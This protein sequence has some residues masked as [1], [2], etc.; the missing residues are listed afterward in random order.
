MSSKVNQWTLLV[1]SLP[2]VFAIAAG[3]FTGLPIDSRQRGELL[4]TAAQSVFAVAVVSSLSVSVKEALALFSLFWAQFLLGAFVPES[5]HGTEL[6]V[7]SAVYILLGLWLLVRK[8]R[9]FRH[10]LRGTASAPPTAEL[11]PEA[12][13]E[14]PSQV[15]R[16]SK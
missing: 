3:S 13:A 4:L 1:G 8:R 5:A 12:A 7:V 9:D 14:G 2:L 6:V 10:L 15:S 16:S 11:Q